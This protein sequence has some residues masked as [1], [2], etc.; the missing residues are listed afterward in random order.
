M[1]KILNP[2]NDAQSG[3]PGVLLQLEQQLVLA[4]VAAGGILVL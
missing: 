4:S 1:T 2:I 3:A